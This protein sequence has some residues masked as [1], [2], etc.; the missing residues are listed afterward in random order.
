[1]E[2]VFHQPFD[3]NWLRKQSITQLFRDSKSNVWLGIDK[4]I[5]KTSEHAKQ[6]NFQYF[7]IGGNKVS[8]I[9]ED[10]YGIG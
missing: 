1:V 4:G 6:S 10:K 7:H 9:T 3:E 2:N 8:A 5:F